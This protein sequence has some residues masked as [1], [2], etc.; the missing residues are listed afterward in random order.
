METRLIVG[1]LIVPPENW[2]FLVNLSVVGDDVNCLFLN[3][4]NYPHMCIGASLP[5]G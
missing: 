4:R 5:V 3:L 1:L 2:L